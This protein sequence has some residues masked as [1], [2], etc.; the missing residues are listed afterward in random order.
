VT[1]T[2][3]QNFVG[4]R[5]GTQ[6]FKVV[7]DAAEPVVRNLEKYTTT[8]A[9]IT[10]RSPN[11]NLDFALAVTNIFDRR[12]ESAFDVPAPGRTFRAS[13]TAKF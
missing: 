7:D 10:W 5:V 6:D 11:G 9:A 3:V 2:V 1:A 12:V 13:L 4:R 8:D